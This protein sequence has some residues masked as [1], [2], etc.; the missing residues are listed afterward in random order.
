MTNPITEGI[1]AGEYLVSEANGNYSREVVTVAG[2]DYGPATVLGKIPS[3]TSS[4]A[5]KSG[6][7]TGNGTIALDG[8]TP[9]QPG[10]KRGTYTVRFTAATAFTVEDPDG[11][12]IGTGATGTAFTDD[13]KFTITAGGTAFVAG[14]GFDIAVGTVGYTYTELD[15]TATDGSQIACAVLFDTAK[16]ASADVRQVAH[17]RACEVNGLVLDW[18]T[19]ITTTQKTAAIADLAAAGIVVRS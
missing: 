12:V 7:N 9:V 18:P 17:V 4:A 6:G 3:A 1:H 13:V 14:D 5:A 8:T 11:N 10:A 19:G 16:A 2:G 15:P